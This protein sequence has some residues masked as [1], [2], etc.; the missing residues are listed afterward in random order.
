MAFSADQPICLNPFELVRSWEEEV[1]VV[2]GLVTAM[3]AP[4]EK[5]SDYQTAGLKRVLWY[6]DFRLCLPI[7][8]Q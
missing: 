7:F 3:A 8:S 1:D 6:S 5:L 4:T 2:A